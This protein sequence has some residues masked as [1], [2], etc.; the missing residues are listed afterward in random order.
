MKAPLSWLKDM[1]SIEITAEE[2]AARMTMA[3]LE[4]EKIE[5]L[6]AE[7]GDKV[8]VAEVLNVTQ[9]PD[10]DRLVLADIQ[11]GEHRLTVVTGAPNIATGQKVVLALAGARLVDAYADEPGKMKTLKPGKIRG[12]MSEGMVCSEKEL[13][14]S[15]EHE[16]ILVLPDD[17][18]VGTLLQHYLGDTVIE[19][20][21]TPNLVHAFSVRGLAGEAGA[22]LNEPVRE[23]AVAS[24]DGVPVQEN[25]VRIDAPQL[26]S[27]YIGVIID[28]VQVEPSPAWLAGRL[29]AAGVR[30]INNLV[31]ITNYVMLEIGQPLHA[32]DLRNVAGERIIV[33]TA[34][35]GE[36]METLDHTMRTFTAADLLITDAEKP[37]AVAGVMGGVNSEV[38]DDTTSI[39]LE[40]A[41]FDM[42]SVRQ[43]GR[44]LK[45]RTDALARFERGLDPNLSWNA[46]MR[47]VQL[48][49]DVCPDATVRCYADEY[50]VKKAPI[51]IS[52]PFVKIEKVLGMAIDAATV[53][54]VLSR[55]G[56]QPVISGETLS[57]TVPTNRSDV[58]LS[59]D[60]IEEVA[61]IVGY[62][63]LPATMPIGETPI[64][65]RDAMFLLERA[66]RESLVAA[67][68]FEG[69]SYVTVSESA[70]QT[71]AGV[72]R[73]STENHLVRLINPLNDAQPVLRTSLLPRLI[74]AVAENLKH[75]KTVRLFEIGHAFFGTTPD[76]L[77][78]EPSHLAFAYAGYREPFNRFAPQVRKLNTEQAAAQELDYFDVKGALEVALERVGATDLTYA[79]S[80]HPALHPGRTA[81]VKV[82]GEHIGTIG[83]VRPDLAKE[84]GVGENRLV[85]AEIDLARVHQLL[86]GQAKMQISVDHFLPVEQDFAFLVD[87]SVPAAD[88]EQALRRNA[89]PLLTDIVLFD[90]FEG[91][92]IG[93][94]KKSLAYRLTFTAPDR[95]LTDAEL[96]KQRVKIQ[97]GVKALVGGE[98]RA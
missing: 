92:Q 85:V 77:P 46:A 50:P 82:K 62:D 17:A 74:D 55:L 39:L 60:V 79:R 53:V 47:A 14:M 12:I 21:I 13:G 94:D 61:R 96:E 87:K 78:D 34:T 45:L 63:N 58:T 48:V 90:V 23:L 3:G 24:M 49:L 15:D 43:T 36:Q 22:I 80:E 31:D 84:L 75:E 6:G 7:W 73:E 2:L 64:V 28:G 20:E 69:R 81:S 71:F 35:D 56:F 37:V 91:K 1:V 89:G 97:K 18:P 25:L 4:A 8:Y 88:V 29:A 54:N 38:L 51:N 59:E 70:Q 72:T 11:A 93:A 30:P 98:L 32:F 9:H 86:G 10:A 40:S 66:V 26:C 83:E 27:R 52:L 68:A 19:F 95:A 42:V 5:H 33:R 67:G 41:N 57:V 65:E 76:E 16:G 44:R